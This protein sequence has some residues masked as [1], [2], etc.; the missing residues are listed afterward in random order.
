MAGRRVGGE[1]RL[2]YDR[3]VQDM[4]VSHER[5][6]DRERRSGRDR[7]SLERRRA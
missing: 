5:R 3:R 2:N 1:R 4:W 7:R 6:S